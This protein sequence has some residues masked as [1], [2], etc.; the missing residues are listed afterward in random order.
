MAVCAGQC[1]ACT[2]HMWDAGIVCRP[3]LLH[4]VDAAI[5]HLH[6]PCLTVIAMPAA[7]LLVVVLRLLGWLLATKQGQAHHAVP[8]PAKMNSKTGPQP[9]RL[10]VQHCSNVIRESFSLRYSYSL[11]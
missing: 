9:H 2:P 4:D 10:H 8:A 1:K 11:E 5:A 3:G 6:A 7:G